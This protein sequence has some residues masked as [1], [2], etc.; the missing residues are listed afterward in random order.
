VVGFSFCQFNGLLKPFYLCGSRVWRHSFSQGRLALIPVVM[1]GMEMA[2]PVTDLS[3]NLVNW[4]RSQLDIN[5]IDEEE[6][7]II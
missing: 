3:F 4:C 6:V 7:K 1:G 5:W 2:S